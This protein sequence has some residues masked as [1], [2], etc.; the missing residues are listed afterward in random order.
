MK[1]TDISRRAGESGQAV[2]EYGV[3]LAL[4]V[5]GALVFIPGLGDAVSTLYQNARDAIDAV[6]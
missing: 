4:I 1:E 6:M 5:V 2:V 3:L